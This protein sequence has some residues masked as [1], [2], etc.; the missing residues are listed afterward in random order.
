[1]EANIDDGSSNNMVKL[2][3]TACKIPS[4]ELDVLPRKPNTYRKKIRKRL[5]SYQ[6]DSISDESG[7]H[8][9]SNSDGDLNLDDIES[10][11]DEYEEQVTCL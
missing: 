2:S 8:D 9:V 4:T 11:D 7:Y 3:K 6:E 10:N 5:C 1:M